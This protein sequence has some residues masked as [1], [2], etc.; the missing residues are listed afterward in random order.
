MGLFL[1]SDRVCKQQTREKWAPFFLRHFPFS[2]SLLRSDSRLNLTRSSSKSKQQSTFFFRPLYPFFTRMKLFFVDLSQVSGGGE[3][4]GP[5]PPPPPS[6]E[7]E[8][9]NCPMMQMRER[10]GI[11]PPSYSFRQPSLSQIF[12]LP[13]L[14]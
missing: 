2:S 7:E 10:R 6:P 4:E 3:G 5:P 1:P 11:S 12:L 14:L 8:G 13:L 9:P